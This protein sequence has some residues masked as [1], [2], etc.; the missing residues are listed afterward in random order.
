MNAELINNYWQVGEYISQRI[1]LATWGEGTVEELALFIE[2]KHPELKGYS[3]TTLYRMRRFY[4]TYRDTVFVSSLVTQLVSTE[5]RGT[6]LVTLPWTH[7][8]IILARAKSAEERIFYMRLSSQE[9]YGKRELDRQISSGLF[10]RVMMGN[11]ELPAPLKD[12]P[13]LAN[14]FRSSYILEFLSLPL[15]HNEGDLQKALIA[16]MKRFILELLCEPLHNSSRLIS[17]TSL[18]DNNM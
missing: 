9:H 4:E 14:T 13:G 18:T 17:R 3:R 5:I 7:H 15:Q 10:E 16:Q 11:Q 12:R 1:G 2:Q 8:L 6:L